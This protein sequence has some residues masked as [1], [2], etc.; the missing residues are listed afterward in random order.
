MY[1]HDEISILMLQI[2]DN[3]VCES[4]YLIFHSCMEPGIF[5]T[6]WKMA[7]VVLNR[8]RDE[9]QNVI[10]YWLDLPLP[11]FRKIFK[12]LADNENF[13]F[14]IKNGLISPNQS[15]FKQGDSYINKFLSITHTIYQS[16][17]QEYEVCCE[18]LDISKSFDKV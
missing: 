3:V 4:L 16:L 8:K 5:P 14:F 2:C 6:K 18:F 9:K 15:H 1:A 7:L 11:I 10:N 13:S 12:P 17:D